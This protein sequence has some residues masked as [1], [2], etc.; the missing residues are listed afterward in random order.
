MIRLAIL[1]Q[2]GK[3][4]TPQDVPTAKELLALV[5]QART[6]VRDCERLAQQ[7][8]AKSGAPK[9]QQIPYMS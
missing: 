3:H 4:L 9:Q 7:M 1:D 5:E 6:V 8:V 2:D